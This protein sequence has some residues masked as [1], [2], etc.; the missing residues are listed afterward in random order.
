MNAIKEEDNRIESVKLRRYSDRLAL[1]GWGVILLG[2]WESV[3][4]AMSIYFNRAIIFDLIREGLD[5]TELPFMDLAFAL[6]V[7]FMVFIYGISLL[8]HLYIGKSAIADSKGK[9]KKNLYLVLAALV[10]LVSV[11][12]PGKKEVPEKEQ[13]E[14]V[15]AEKEIDA[16]AEISQAEKDIDTAAEDLQ[17]END[18]NTDGEKGIDTAFATELLDITMWFACAEMVYC[19][20]R[21]RIL[22]RKF[23]KEAVTEGAR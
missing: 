3:R 19:G 14:I 8:I 1:S 5:D 4:A 22:R 13:A 11:L 12:L 21:T 23:A 15:Q 2:I 18:I 6:F 20:I 16:A 10:V 17:E 7:G 9:K